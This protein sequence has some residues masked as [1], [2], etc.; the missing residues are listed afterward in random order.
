MIAHN[1][2][3]HIYRDLKTIPPWLIIVGRRT[4]CFSWMIQ[5]IR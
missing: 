1:Q 3:G 2:G 4:E 5:E